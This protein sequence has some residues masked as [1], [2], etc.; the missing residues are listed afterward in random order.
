MSP[1]KWI[2]SSKQIAVRGRRKP[3]IGVKSR[4]WSGA[5]PLMGAKSLSWAPADS[6]SATTASGPTTWLRSC[7][8]TR[9][10]TLLLR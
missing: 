5:G 6:G 4:F 9:D 1:L 7:E 2:P 8:P 10:Y 3:L